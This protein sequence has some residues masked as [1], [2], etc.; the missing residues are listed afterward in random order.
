MDFNFPT[1]DEI[2]TAYQG[3]EAEV[4][5]LFGGTVVTLPKTLQNQVEAI[6]D[7]NFIVIKEKYLT[8]HHYLCEEYFLIFSLLLF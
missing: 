1:Q 2:C 7:S 6:K 4:P 3:G 5:E 8:L